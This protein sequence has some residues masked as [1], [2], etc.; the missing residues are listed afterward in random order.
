M[1]LNDGFGEGRNQD[2]YGGPKADGSSK[3][4]KDSLSYRYAH[5]VSSLLGNL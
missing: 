4:S 2:I 1:A 3:P 5:G